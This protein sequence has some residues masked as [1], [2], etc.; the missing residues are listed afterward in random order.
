MLTFLSAR[1]LST[2]YKHRGQYKKNGQSKNMLFIK[3]PQIY[4][5]LLKL[6]EIHPSMG[7]SNPKS[8]SKIG[9]KSWICYK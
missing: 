4:L 5:I 6:S 3:D 8:L 2:S 1:I 7:R 9:Q